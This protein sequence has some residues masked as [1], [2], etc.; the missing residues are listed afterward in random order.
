MPAVK[1][2]LVRG[3]Q[4]PYRVAELRIR[5]QDL[6]ASSVHYGYPRLWVLFRRE[7]W[8]VN[9]KLVSRLDCEKGLAI[10][11]SRASKSHQ[12]SE[13]SANTRWLDCW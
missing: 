4:V 6:A 10:R 12:R 7:G 8:L 11:T 3:V 2:V 1:R 5:L 13:N 9:K